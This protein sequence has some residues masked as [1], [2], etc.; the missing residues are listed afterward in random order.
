MLGGGALRTVAAVVSLASAASGASWKAVWSPKK[1]KLRPA[2]N[3]SRI[4]LRRSPSRSERGATVLA[5]LREVAVKLRD[6]PGNVLALGKVIGG[7][8]GVEP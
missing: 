4:R 1:A 8:L 2:V 6:I 3:D 7:A 5:D